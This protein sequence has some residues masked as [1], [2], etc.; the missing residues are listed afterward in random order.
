MF[1]NE[2]FPFIIFMFIIVWY[3]VTQPSPTLCDPMDCSPPSSS[4]HGN[5]S[6]KNTRVSCHALFQGIFPTHVLNQG[7]L[8]C[9]WILYQLSYQV[10]PFII[11]VF[12]LSLREFPENSWKT[13]L[14]GFNSFLAFL[15]PVKYLISPWNLN[16]CLVV[17]SWL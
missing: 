7:L 4:V 2:L 14:M 1:T 10:C 6:G 12:P 8:H 17:H 15:L 5:S 9:R 16:K 13:R 11:V 3:L